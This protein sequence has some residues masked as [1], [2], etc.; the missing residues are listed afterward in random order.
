MIQ[1]I[2]ETSSKSGLSMFLLTLC[3]CL[4]SGVIIDDNSEREIGGTS[5]KSR[6]NFK[7]TIYFHSKKKN[8]NEANSIE[9]QEIPVW[10]LQKMVTVDYLRTA[11]WKWANIW[12]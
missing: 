2:G 9:K 5:L 11:Y 6:Y 4:A 7:A 1:K 3:S 12:W 8:G 10:R